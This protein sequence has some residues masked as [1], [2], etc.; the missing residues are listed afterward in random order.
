LANIAE[1]SDHN[2]D[3]WLEPEGLDIALIYPQGQS[4]T[5]PDI[6][7]QKLVNMMPGL[8][9]EDTARETPP[10]SFRQIVISVKT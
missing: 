10:K 7:Q 8:E 9:D 3:H 6:L 2:I 1:N 5:L 4:C